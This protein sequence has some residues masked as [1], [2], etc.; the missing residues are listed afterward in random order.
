MLKNRILFSKTDRAIWISHLDTMHT[1]QRAFV[2][3]GVRVCHSEGFNPHPMMSIALPL[4]V[5]MESVCEIIDVKTENNIDI[6]LLNAVLPEGLRIIDIYD[7]DSKIANIKWLEIEGRYSCDYDDELNEL[8]ERESIIINKKSKRGYSDTDIKPMIKSISFSDGLM[9]A[10]IAAQNPTL[11]PNN[12][13]EAVK[14]LKPEL[15]F[16]DIRFKRL[17]LLDENMVE[18]R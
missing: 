8:F 5:G 13:V 10:V 12:I 2:R 1:L 18:F 16:N 3:A 17:R 6:N 15:A 7:F 4:S 9:T 14:Q 11:N